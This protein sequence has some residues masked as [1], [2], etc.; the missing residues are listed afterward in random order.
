MLTTLHSLFYFIKEILNSMEC[1]YQARYSVGDDLYLFTIH[2]DC[3]SKLT[4]ERLYI[5]MNVSRKLILILALVLTYLL[6]YI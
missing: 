3:K 6:L 1:T 2:M 4:T 5:Y